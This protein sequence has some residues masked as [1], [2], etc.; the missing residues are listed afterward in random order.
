[1]AD[2]KVPEQNPVAANLHEVECM[3]CHVKFQAQFPQPIVDNKLTYSIIV[4][5]HENFLKCPGC[6]QPH[7]FFINPQQFQILIGVAALERKSAAQPANKDGGGR[8]IIPPAGMNFRR[9]N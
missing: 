1:M 2:E 8:I 9:E 3:K 7:G 5:V 6:G 4:L